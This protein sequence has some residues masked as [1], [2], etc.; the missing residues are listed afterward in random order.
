MSYSFNLVDQPFIPCLMRGG[1]QVELGLQ[2]TLLRA[3]DI[4]EIRDG[5]PLVTIALHRLLLAVLHRNF[6]P[7]SLKDW[8]RLWQAGR[9]DE[10]T[11]AAYFRR[12]RDR[13]DL[14]DGARPFY[15]TAGFRA[16]KL[17]TANRL[18][19]EQ[20][21][22]N[23]AT[24]FDHTTDDNPPALTPAQAVRLVIAQQAFGLGG[25]HSDTGSLHHAP[26]VQ[27]AVVFPQG[28]S[29]FETLMLNLLCYSDQEPMPADADAPVWEREDGPPHERPTAPAGYLDYLTWQSRTLMLHPEEEDGRSVVRS[30]SYAQGRQFEAPG[31]FDPMMAY[32]KD[33]KQGW[34]PLRLSE[35]K[36]LWRDSAALF[37]LDATGQHKRPDCFNWLARLVEG[38]VL[39]AAQR[40]DFAVFGLCSDRAKVNFWRHDRMPL[41]LAYL[42][43]EMLVASLQQALT[44]AEEVAK[45]LRKCVWDMAT[46]VLSPDKKS[47]D[48]D[49]VQDV[50][51]SLAPDRLYWSRL[52]IPFRRFLVGLAEEPDHQEQAVANWVR[53]ELCRQARQAFE[54]T[55]GA[56]DHSARLLRAVTCS[57]R[58][59]TAGL[60]TIARAYEEGLHGQD[61]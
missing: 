37:Q 51:D 43:D 55:A 13:F 5:S 57:R 42:N 52:E 50:V 40:L 44:R 22:G 12:W 48:A 11:L 58:Q 9:W 32:C 34:R 41:P 46:L 4:R 1:G 3:P 28:H 2:D 30:V 16:K 7:A 61:S 14:F 60:G 54:Q 47:V 38:G 20:A 29:L 21:S 24:L 35:H 6:G 59:L 33:E 56:W 25:G 19:H 10:A 36:E 31:V 23:N 17:S 53:L 39:T 18:A 8:K 49:R 15:Q 27:G 26:L 45:V